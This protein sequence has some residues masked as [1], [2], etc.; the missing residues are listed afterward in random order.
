M[1]RLWRAYTVQP[2]EPMASRT[3][4]I[5]GFSGSGK[6]TAANSVGELL[7]LRIIHPSSIL[8]DIIE[9][10]KVDTR[11]TMHNE[12]FW[13]SREG[14]NMFISRLNDKVPPDVVSDRIILREAKKG[15][16]VIDSWSLPWL[17]KN[18]IKTYLKADAATRARRV[19]ARDNITY[20]NALN[21]IRIKDEGTRKLFKRVYG[22]DIRKDL[23]V[24]DSIVP[25]R[26]KGKNEVVEEIMKI[27]NSKERVV[28][29]IK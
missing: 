16:V 5:F 21:A 3:I 4:I 10:K 22:F 9:K 23:Q 15:N 11:N 27:I 20:R 2:R 12:G 1:S 25:T 18:G 28:R 24:F 6:S 19:A 29:Q 14:M 13:E 7:G 17:A 26:G 8:R